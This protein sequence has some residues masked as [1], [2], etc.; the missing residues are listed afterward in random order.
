MVK[1]DK[2]EKKNSAAGGIYGG[3]TA[4]EIRR[5]VIFLAHFQRTNFRRRIQRSAAAEG[6]AATEAVSTVTRISLPHLYRPC[7]PTID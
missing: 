3:F 2:N 5:A 4:S 7:L 6:L 1:S